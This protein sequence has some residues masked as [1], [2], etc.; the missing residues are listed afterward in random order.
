M[1]LLG[2]RGWM[3][4]AEAGAAAAAGYPVEC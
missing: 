2:G 3:L 1:V 4:P